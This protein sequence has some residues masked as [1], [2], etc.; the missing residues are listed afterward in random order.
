MADAETVYL[1]QSAHALCLNVVYGDINTTQFTILQQDSFVSRN[2]KLEVRT[3]IIGGSHFVSVSNGDIEL[4]EVFACVE[5][6]T[7]GMKA[8]CGNLDSIKDKVLWQW[9][10]QVRYEFQPELVYGVEAINRLTELEERANRVNEQPYG[11]GM[12]FVFP[13]V[14]ETIFLPKT[15]LVVEIDDVCDSFAITTAHAYP[16]EKIA[17]FTKSKMNIS[18]G[19]EN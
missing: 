16:N 9:G 19:E 14:G 18:L 12:Q 4:H 11:I 2:G 6:V 17:V 5:V 15:I 13:S 10:N 1:D 3:G 7:T 8:F